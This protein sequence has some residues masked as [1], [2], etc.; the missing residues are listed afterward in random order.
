M[1]G[2]AGDVEAV[3]RPVSRN[4]NTGDLYCYGLCSYGLFFMAYSYGLQLG[5]PVPRNA[6]TGD[7]Y[8]YGLY[9]YGLYSYGVYSYGLQ[10]VDQC[11][12]MQVSRHV[13]RHVYRPFS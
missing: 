11:L 8:G 2:E 4:A 13:H 9:S 12:A 3:G 7:L 6:N 5:R 10:L 1:A